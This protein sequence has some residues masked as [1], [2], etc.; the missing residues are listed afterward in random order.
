MIHLATPA[1]RGAR[2][3][4]EPHDGT[5]IIDTHTLVDMRRVTKV[6]GDALSIKDIIRL[7][8][9]D[10]DKTERL[11]AILTC[12]DITDAEKLEQAAMLV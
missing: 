4:S 12:R 3:D 5:I 8:Q 7:L 9:T 11:K 2:V 10:S 1:S 6:G